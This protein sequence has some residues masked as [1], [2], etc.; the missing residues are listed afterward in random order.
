[1]L[2]TIILREI[3]NH[4]FNL[5]FQIGIL[6]VV[7]TFAIGTVS[8]LKSQRNQILQYIEFETQFRREM[9]EQAESNVGRLAVDKRIYLMQPRQNSFI[10]DCKEKY[11]PKILMA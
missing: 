4:I 6:V 2:G 9:Q 10:A 7:S 5:R 1:M 11:L 3:Q 8:S